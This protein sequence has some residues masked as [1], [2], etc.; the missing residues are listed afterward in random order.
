MCDWF[1][2]TFWSKI[3]G[4]RPFEHFHHESKQRLC[5][6]RVP[7]PLGMFVAN[8]RMLGLNLD[9]LRGIS[10]HCPGTLNTHRDWDVGILQRLPNQV[11]A[12]AW[13]VCILSFGKPSSAGHRCTCLFAKDHLGNRQKRGR[14]ASKI[15]NDKFS[16]VRQVAVA[17]TDERVVTLALAKGGRVNVCAKPADTGQNTGVESRLYC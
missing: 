11:S 8:K 5:Q 13:Y 9:K 12:F 15:T 4:N 14:R 16:L 10:L 17:G 1:N 7:P 6:R 2:C 3:A